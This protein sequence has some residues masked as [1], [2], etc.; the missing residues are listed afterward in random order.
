MRIYSFIGTSTAL[1][2]LPAVVGLTGCGAPEGPGPATSSA[3]SSESKHTTAQ[4][5]IGNTINYG[6]FGTTAE[7]DCADGKSLNVGGSNNT[8]TVRGTCESVNVIGADNKITIDK[9]DK[10]L[11]ITGINN[12]VTYNGGEPK[13]DD[14]GSGNTVNHKS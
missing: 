11:S 1:V 13:I 9:I 8:L 7:V 2:I 14:H 12:T 5:E 6:S 4:L 10:T 3:G